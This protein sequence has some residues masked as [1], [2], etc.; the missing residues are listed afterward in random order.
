MA[1]LGQFELLQERL[2]GSGEV[3][4]A[5]G[6]R[7]EVEVL[8]DGQGIEQPRIVGHEGQLLLGR[9]RVRDDVV[10]AD[11]EAVRRLAAGFRPCHGG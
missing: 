11:R 9:D 8:P 3:G 7:D 4:H 10:P 1:L 5:V 6:R 2:G